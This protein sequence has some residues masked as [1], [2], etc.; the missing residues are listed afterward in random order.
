MLI[1]VRDYCKTATD[2][3]GLVEK[4]FRDIESKKALDDFSIAKEI[5]AG[6]SRSIVDAL[7][8]QPNITGVGVDL[9]K[10]IEFFKPR[11][12]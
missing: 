4:I 9:K 5:R 11:K 3:V 2:V 6:N 7:I 1:P 12:E 10:I 8:L